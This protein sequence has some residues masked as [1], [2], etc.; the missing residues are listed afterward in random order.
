MRWYI[1]RAGLRLVPIA[2]ISAF[3]GWLAY[4]AVVAPTMSDGASDIVAGSFSF[5]AAAATIGLGT[6]AVAR[7]KTFK[8]YTP[9]ER[10]KARAILAATR[11]LHRQR[12]SRRVI[13][14][15]IDETTTLRVVSPRVIEII[16]GCWGFVRGYE[17]TCEAGYDSGPDDGRGQMKTRLHISVSYFDG[18]AMA[19]AAHEATLRHAS[20]EELD[21]LLA[22]LTTSVDP[23]GLFSA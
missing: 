6:A 22:R 1:M 14:I 2:L 13:F 17:S 21:E 4:K 11:K 10:R 16:R 7:P 18:G 20:D 5:A 15:Q 19:Q 9:A 8:A 23:V 12:H 3:F